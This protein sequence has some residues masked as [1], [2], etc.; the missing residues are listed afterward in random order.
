FQQIVLED[1]ATIGG[2]ARFDMRNNGANLNLQNHTLTKIG[3]IAFG[4]GSVSIGDGTI[5]VQV[6]SIS[7]G[8]STS[9]GDNGQ[10]KFANATALQFNALSGG[11]VSRPMFFTGTTNITSTGTNSTCASTMNFNG[12]IA[13]NSGTSTLNLT[14]YI[15]EQAGTTQNLTKS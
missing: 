6:G 8:G 7:L 5:D 4:M 3:S 9:A 13:I 1:D 14:G 10:F 11:T 12:P 2:T 15:L